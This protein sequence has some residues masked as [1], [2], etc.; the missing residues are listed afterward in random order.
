MAKIISVTNQ[1]GGVGKTT[2]CVSL[3]SELALM[4]KRVLLVDLDPQASASSGLSI[5][6][7]PPGSDLYDVF[8]GRLPL[9]DIIKSSKINGLEIVP[10]SKDLIGIEIE[11]GKAPGRELILKSEL[12]MLKRSF[13]YIFI[14][15]PPSSGLLT[16]NAVGAS[17]YLIIPLQAEYYALEGLSALMGTVEF[18]K[19]TFNQRL[20]ILGVFLTMYDARTNLSSQVQNEA[21]EFFKERMFN[22]VIPRNIKISESPSHGLPICLYDPESTGAKAYHDLAVELDVRCQGLEGVVPMA[23]NA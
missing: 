5:E 2:S 13:D 4:G 10:S 16:L 3:A 9:K 6:L 21:R 8:F 1:K 12:T 14:D 23:A 17:D 15:C 7:H 18:V 11:L 19:Q 20:E 22:T